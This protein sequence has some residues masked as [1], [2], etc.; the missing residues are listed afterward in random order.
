M[1]EILRSVILKYFFPKISSPNSYRVFFEDIAQDEQSPNLRYINTAPE[2][3]SHPVITPAQAQEDRN[4]PHGGNMA[5][6]LRENVYSLNEPIGSINS[7][8]PQVPQ[9]ESN[10]W[11]K[12]NATSDNE[13]MSNG[14]KKRTQSSF[15]PK[16]TT[17]HE[18]HGHLDRD[19][20]SKSGVLQAHQ[21]GLNRHAYNPNTKGAVGIVP[22]TEYK[23]YAPEDQER[24]LV[25]RISYENMYNARDPDNY[26]M[27]A[28]VNCIPLPSVCISCTS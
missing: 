28:R 14:K 23:N 17:Y 4:R 15:N 18:Q 1:H 25:D 26:P 11:W 24:V 9:E 16:G 5:T 22:V 19:F 21:S 6:F 13:S 12:W 10:Q 8:A 2:M 27:R 20:Y 7:I 3:Y